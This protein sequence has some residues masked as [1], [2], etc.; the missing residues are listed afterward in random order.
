M[1]KFEVVGNRKIEKAEF[2]AFERGGGFAMW[3]RL[4]GASGVKL[5]LTR[6]TQI[7]KDHLASTHALIPLNIIHFSSMLK[8]QPF[9]FFYSPP[10]Q[11]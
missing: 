3:S 10:L 6:L 7:K 9:L 5:Q 1:L 8:I 11:I 2:L 4:W